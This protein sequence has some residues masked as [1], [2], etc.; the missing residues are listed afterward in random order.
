MIAFAK[1]LKVGRMFPNGVSAVLRWAESPIS[2]AAADISKPRT[3]PFPHLL[4]GL[5]FHPN[6][7]GSLFCEIVHHSQF[8][9]SSAAFPELSINAKLSLTRLTLT[10]IRS[11]FVILLIAILLFNYGVFARSLEVQQFEAKGSVTTISFEQGTTNSIFEL[12]AEFTFQFSN[13]WWRVESLYKSGKF[14]GVDSER[15]RESGV[16]L[17][18]AR[19]PDGVR[20][21][22]TTKASKN[23]PGGSEI[24]PPATAL[25]IF[26]P[27]P[28]DMVLFLPWL[29][30]CPSPE[31][32][33]ID[34]EFMRRF[35]ASHRINDP[36]NRATYSMSFLDAKSF[37]L[38]ELQITNLGFIFIRDGGTAPLPQ[39][40]DSGFMEHHYLVADTIEYNGSKFPRRGVLK[41]YWPRRSAK[42]F[43]EVDIVGLSTFEVESIAPLSNS[44]PSSTKILVADY[45]TKTNQ[46]VGYLVVND[47]WMA[48][49]DPKLKR[50]SNALDSENLNS[51]QSRNPPV[52]IVRSLFAASILAS[53]VILF[54]IVRK[55]P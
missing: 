20:C 11:Y 49:N 2:T 55:K 37:V 46:A 13:G 25:P 5:N 33:L 9:S 35:S 10:R 32:P 44:T 40:F 51:I 14:P 18:C 48:A 3:D 30:L 29:G 6:G 21:F 41:K 45:R 42:Q 36:E 28:E 34:D 26:F 39:P 31:L 38:G 22:T 27:P 4:G 52:W 53:V 12:Q 16:I 17:D 1:V 47:K 24:V 23:S 43:S 7:R 54:R 8:G 15:F 19:V 50:Y